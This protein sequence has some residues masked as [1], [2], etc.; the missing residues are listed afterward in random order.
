MVNLGN[1]WDKLLKEEFNKPYYLALRQFLIEEYRTQVIYPPKEDLFNAL[2][3]TSYQDTKVVILGQDPYHGLGQAHGMAFSVNPGIAIPPSLRNIYKELQDSL[4]CSIP[5]NGYLMPWA[6]QG[7]LLINTVLT[8]RAGQPQ[9]HQNKGWEI[10][11][12]EI[13]K[14]LNQKDETVIFLLWGSPAKKKMNLIT[15]PKHVVLTAVHPSP[16][17]AH[18]GFFGCNHFKQVNEILERQGRET[19]DWQISN[20]KEHT[21]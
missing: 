8:V 11:T 6:K 2:K 4:G 15:N 17:S 21:I 18:R 19:I 12:D 20:L 5:D 3:A 16:L 1:D 14:L 13:I 10:L 7:V 9:S